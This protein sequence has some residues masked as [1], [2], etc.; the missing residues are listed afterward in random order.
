MVAIFFINLSN[1]ETAKTTS[2]TK[3]KENTMRKMF[4]VLILLFSLFVIVA[5]C[6]CID[7]RE[8]DELTEVVRE[9]NADEVEVEETF[10]GSLIHRW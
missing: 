10:I 7:G 2:C 4:I 8:E 9:E 1:I 6:N 3:I 5:F